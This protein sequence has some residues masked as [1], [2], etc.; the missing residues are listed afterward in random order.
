MA[1]SILFLS[2]IA[3][4]LLAWL[5]NKLIFQRIQPPQNFQPELQQIID[6]APLIMWTEKNNTV[7]WSNA[8]C[9]TRFEKISQTGIAAFDPLPKSSRNTGSKRMRLQT[10]GE[11]DPVEFVVE[12]VLLDDKSI[13]YA[14]DAKPLIETEQELQRFIQ[15]LTGTFAHL[16]IGLAIFDKKRDLSL[17]NP[18]LSDLLNLPAEWLIRRPGLISF[19]DR[20]RSEG[21]MPEPDDFSSLRQEFQNLESGA[22]EGNYRAEWTLANGRIYRVVGRPHIQ[23][24]L[25]LLFEDISKSVMVER[26]YRSELEQLYSAF[27]SLADGVAIFDPSGELVFVND[28]FDE[29][30]CSDMAGA[31]APV[32]VIDFTR[33]LQERCAPTPA[34]GD[35]RQFVLEPAERS[36]WQAS[37]TLNT[38][39]TVLGTFSP[40]TGGQVFGEFKVISNPE[41][42][43]EEMP[44]PAKNQ[45]S[46]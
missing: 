25:A 3:G 28:A 11:N 10:P 43:T 17:F 31:L 44:R 29:L 27:D 4:A 30:W 41:P 9:Q 37:F 46:A 38:G 34:W 18:A 15:T 21:I 2:A 7:I 45:I 32:N 14:S 20:L 8:P 40:I 19:L 5:T 26:Q 39:E 42:A 6:N 13:Y 35:F 12:H 24:G 33:T 22:V 36:Q 23:G 16:P 1:P